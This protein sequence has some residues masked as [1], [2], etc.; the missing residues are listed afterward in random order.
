MAMPNFTMKEL[1]EAGIHFGHQTNRWNPKMETYLYGERNGIHIIDLQQTVPL[2]NNALKVLRDVAASG[3]RVLFVGTKRQAQKIVSE[4]AVNSGQYFMNHRWLGGTLT[5]W[6]TISKSIDRLKGYDELLQKEDSG[7]TKKEI[8]GVQ[9]QR[10]KLD[11]SLG[12]IKDMSGVPDALFVIDT[13][14]EHIAIKEANVLNIPVIAVVD[15][16]SNPEGVDYPIPGNDDAT[17]SISLYCRLVSES[18]L[19]GLKDSFSS[20]GKDIGASSEGLVEENINNLSKSKDKISDNKDKKSFKGKIT[21]KD[22]DKNTVKDL[23]KSVGKDNASSKEVKDINASKPGDDNKIKD[24]PKKDNSKVFNDEPKDNTKKSKIVADTKANIKSEKKLDN[25]EEKDIK[26][27]KK[28]DASKNEKK[29]KES[30][31]QNKE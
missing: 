2:L 19:D 1:L 5:N 31:N 3:G 24:K 7:L 14:K 30:T 22:S 11:S 8:V 26:I 20:S 12:G 27:S 28:S 6:S 15:S 17:R 16:N 29:S 23:K 21:N 9:R 18:I 10:N 13:N 4:N 25:K